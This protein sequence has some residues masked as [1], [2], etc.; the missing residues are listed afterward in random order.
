MAKDK[1]K[2]YPPE[3]Y[4]IYVRVPDGD[5][6]TADDIQAFLEELAHLLSDEHK[7]VTVSPYIEDDPD[8]TKVEPG[9][10]GGGAGGG[11]GGSAGGGA[12]GGA[13]GKSAFHAATGGR[14][15]PLY[16]MYVCHNK[17]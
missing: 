9:R 10:R 16:P 12:G 7:D 17:N 1:D 4:Q 5:K 11:A 6:A 13:A 3:G 8:V 14:R 2:S 15:S